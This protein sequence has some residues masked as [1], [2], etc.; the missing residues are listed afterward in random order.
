MP[1]TAADQDL[2]L[3]LLALRMDFIAREH[4]IAAMEVWGVDKSSSLGTVLVEQ[5]ALDA[6][7]R[8]LLERLVEEHLKQHDNDFAK[9]LAS[10][11][12]LH[13]LREELAQIANADVH[14]RLAHISAVEEEAAGKGRL[15]LT[16]D[17]P[18]GASAGAS[19]S[20][21]VA[22]LPPRD[23]SA[24][25][26][27]PGSAMAR[28]I[29]EDAVPP[30]PA[31]TGSVHGY[32]ILAELGRGGMGVVYKA[33]QVALNRLVALKMIL[34]GE[35]ASATDLARFRTEAEAIARLAHSNI[36]HI[37]EI[38]EHESRPYFSLEYCDGGSLAQR[39]NGAPW[40][41]RDAARI[42]EILARAMHA[43]HQKGII[44]RDLKPANILLQIS[45]CSSQIEAPG[46]SPEQSA[47]FNVQS[48]IPKIT[49][50][51]LAK[52]LDDVGRTASG[53]I[54]GTPS[55]MAPEQAGGKA[56]E[57]GPAADTYALGAILYELLTGR[58]PFRAATPLDTILQVVSDPP[59]PPTQLQS[60][61]PRDLE[62]ICLKCLAKEPGRRYGSAEE[63]SQDLSRWLRVSRSTHGRWGAS[64]V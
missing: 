63:L 34:A 32:E 19:A 13:S 33:R 62:T 49:D 53:A 31:V 38:G 43:A 37:Y 26:S 2:L 10:L 4:L 35:Y 55:Y 58:P 45:D 50:F 44:H 42:V 54:M 40:P 11:N 57:L 28:G 27:Y 30:P 17:W 25:T 29:V 41:P 36:V 7:R 15:P 8:I 39:M 18:A 46:D 60:K 23:P 48:A 21:E 3:G 1:S 12:V 24:G 61:T 5:R 52:K 9:S 16:Q 6:S 56:R 64:N 51:G 14:A 47:I 22:T 59:V 20:D